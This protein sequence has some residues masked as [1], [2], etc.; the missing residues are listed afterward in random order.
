MEN[1]EQNKDLQ[2]HILV[3]DF[4]IFDMNKR[5]NHKSLISFRRSTNKQRLSLP[6][7]GRSLGA[8]VDQYGKSLREAVHYLKQHLSGTSRT[9]DLFCTP[10]KS[11]TTEPIEERIAW[12]A[13]NCGIVNA[14]AE[15]LQKIP[16]IEDALS[17]FLADSDFTNEMIFTKED[18]LLL[19]QADKILENVEPS[20]DFLDLLPYMLEPHGHVT[21]GQLERNPSSGSIREKKR[22]SG[23]FYTPSDVVLFM[24]QSLIE[25]KRSYGKWLDPACG[26]GAFLREILEVYLEDNPEKNGIAFCEE[27][28][29]GMDISTLATESC[30]FVLLGMCAYQGELKTESP[31]SAWHRIKSNIV[32]C[33][34]MLVKR[35]KKLPTES[36]KIQNKQ[37]NLHFL[38]HDY[39]KRSGQLN[40][41]DKI[42]FEQLFPGI[43]CGFDHVIMNP[44]YA[45]I[46]MSSP[47]KTW[48][49][50]SDL[51][52]GSKINT[53]LAFVEMMSNFI[54]KNGNSAAVLPL[55]VGVSTR[56]Q[57]KKCRE[58][59]VNSGGSWEFLFFDRQPQSL[60]GEDI[61]TR[62]TILLHYHH[63]NDTELKT[64][65]LIKWTNGQRR[66]I[67]NRTRLVKIAAKSISDFVP[68]L[69]TSLELE[70][71]S[72]LKKTTQIPSFSPSRIRRVPLTSIDNYTKNSIFFVGSTAYNFLNCFF[73]IPTNN[74]KD[75]SLSESPVTL[76]EFET[77]EKALA[78]FTL[79]ASRL[80]FWL[81]HVEGDGFHVTNNF[82]KNLPIWNLSLSEVEIKQLA[83]IGRKGW[84]CA[85]KSAVPAVNSGKLTYSFHCPFNTTASIEA[86][87]IILTNLKIESGFSAE[88][89]RFIQETVS[90]DGKNRRSLNN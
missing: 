31:Y 1:L 35:R 9:S 42:P 70:L 50:Y 76:L 37:L 3:S 52:K 5:L 43:P 62:N 13:V 29:F 58:Y 67:F 16:S 4:G 2:N 72:R 30:T 38:E 39:G 47:Y 88:L 90:I 79:T 59:I 81:W 36:N 55:S 89:D 84:F 28:L 22:S 77:E 80:S 48:H 71:Y 34:S 56:K 23:V 61:K 12:F 68:K 65:G 14:Y 26:T 44:P 45:N 60:F 63:S 19:R 64:S 86:E 11:I 74:E 66:N 41:T 8:T 46:T 17:W 7:K 27:H 54:A 15:R 32:P 87:M 20:L 73:S 57:Y 51:K 85:R 78:A 53:S 25:G 49:S 83:D 6:V 40:Q 33:D 69:R 10:T 82:F 21:R 75:R 24:I 18:A